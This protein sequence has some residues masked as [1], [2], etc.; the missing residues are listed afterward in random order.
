MTEFVFVLFILLS[1]I[2]GRISTSNILLHSAICRT[3]LQHQ[4]SCLTLFLKLLLQS[5]NNVV[6]FTVQYY[7]QKVVA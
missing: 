6:Y 3:R 7:W 2:H 5:R 4:N 1:C